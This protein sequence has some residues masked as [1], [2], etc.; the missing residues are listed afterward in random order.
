LEEY[1]GEEG[2]RT[3]VAGKQPPELVRVVDGQLLEPDHGRGQVGVLLSV[4]PTGQYRAGESSD[5]SVGVGLGDHLVAVAFPGVGVEQVLV[6]G[7]GD[8]RLE[9]LIGLLVG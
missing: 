8:S 3:G 2:V 5:E 7:L 4:G 9:L 6:G 1:L